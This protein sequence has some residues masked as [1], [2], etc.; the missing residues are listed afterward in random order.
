MP[1]P[2]KGA[3]SALKAYLRDQPLMKS[4]PE[5]KDFYTWHGSPRSFMPEENHPLGRFLDDKIGSG[6]GAQAFTYGHYTTGSKP[7]A[8]EYRDT[9]AQRHGTAPSSK[10]QTK[11]EIA[12]ISPD[13]I[14]IPPNRFNH[15]MGQ[16]SGS[17]AFWASS[18]KA[19]EKYE[20]MIGN[21]TWVK[22]YL[23]DGS[24]YHTR[25]PGEAEWH[26]L[27]HD[28]VMADTAQ[29]I[30]GG[31]KHDWFPEMVVDAA[32]ERVGAM[33]QLQSAE[34]M[35]QRLE[36]LPPE[37]YGRLAKYMDLPA[38]PKD[39]SAKAWRKALGDTSGS[40]R[41]DSWQRNESLGTLIGQDANLRGGLHQYFDLPAEYGNGNYIAD[42]GVVGRS[43]LID[44]ARQLSDPARLAEIRAHFG[45]GDVAGPSAKSLYRVK[46]D[47]S[48]SDLWFL[49]TPLIGQTDE[50][51]K[52]FLDAGKAMAP[53]FGERSALASKGYD[54][55]DWLKNV[56]KAS[57]GMTSHPRSPQRNAEITDYLKQADVPGAMYLRGG[58]RD[59]D[60]A[61]QKD[62]DPFDFNFV[63]Y[64][65]E[66][67]SIIERYRLGGSVQ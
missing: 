24:S 64:D 14:L 35:R 29:Q 5:V 21:P 46:Q 54:T 18:D 25:R 16:A 43:G 32:R 15:T 33:R 36:Q 4:L 30:A 50:F 26:R 49:D 23:R 53:A 10:L 11:G 8:I 60:A 51:I 41:P 63:T 47:M 20:R 3:L 65:P 58:R 19:G 6:E 22:N 59:F 61:L 1:P 55:Y 66:K 38:D 17:P 62:F 31:G 34:K 7:L 45:I 12:E 40:Y 48:P 42:M 13:A 44:Y 9:L 28:P 57:S 37:L 39:V 52:P 27:S 56:P 2:V 67:A